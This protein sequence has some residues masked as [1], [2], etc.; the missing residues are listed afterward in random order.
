[1]SF[2]MMDNHI[3]NWIVS[4]NDNHGASLRCDGKRMMHVI[5]CAHSIYDFYRDGRLETG[6]VTLC[7]NLLGRARDARASTIRSNMNLNFHVC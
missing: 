2:R 4:K 3:I 1:M 6:N 7:P 5:H